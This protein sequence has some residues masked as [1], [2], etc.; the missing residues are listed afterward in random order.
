MMTFEEYV[1]QECDKCSLS[2]P[3]QRWDRIHNHIKWMILNEVLEEWE[4]F[5]ALKEMKFDD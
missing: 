1:R 4:R 3:V 2:P 5:E